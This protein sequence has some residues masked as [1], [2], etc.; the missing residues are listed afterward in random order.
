M[1]CLV[2]CARQAG[3]ALRH[4][5]E[6]ISFMEVGVVVTPGSQLAAV[7]GISLAW[8]ENSSF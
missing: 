5:E 8:G 4:L 1:Q 2:S 3:I 7:L 6:G